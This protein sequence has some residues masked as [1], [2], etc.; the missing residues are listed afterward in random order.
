MPAI[1]KAAAD[2]A[3]KFGNYTLLRLPY[4]L[5]EMSSDWL[6]VHFDSNLMN[7]LSFNNVNNV[8]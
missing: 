8:S 2:A 5:K 6:E 4:S 7:A 1:L 3:A